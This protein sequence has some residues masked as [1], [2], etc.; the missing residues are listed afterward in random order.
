MGILPNHEID[1]QK[2]LGFSL[3][4]GIGVQ[5]DQ[6]LIAH[7]PGLY[8]HPGGAQLNESATQKSD[9]SRK[10]PPQPQLAMI[11]RQDVG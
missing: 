6:H 8:D 3:N 2:P 4:A 5:T 11:D 9:H 10:I 7:T 1:M